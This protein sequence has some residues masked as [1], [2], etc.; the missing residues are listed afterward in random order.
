[1]SD[2]HYSGSSDSSGLK[3][4]VLFGAVIA[5][6]A[7]NVYLY[8]QVDQMRTDMAA[9]RDSIS[10]EVSGLR[11]ASNVTSASARKTVEDLKTQ[12]DAARQQANQAA[13][14]AK[15]E[16]LARAESLAKQL[17]EEQR[18]QAQQVS[19]QISEVKETAQSANA[20]IDTV[21]TD[22][23]AVRTEVTNAKST[24]EKT[25]ADLK[26]VT[27]DLGVQ[28]GYIATNGKE[29]AALKRLGERNYFEFNLAKSKQPVKVGDISVQL[30]RTDTK[31]NRFTIDIYADDKRVEKKDRTLNEPVQFYVS[32]ARQPYEL[33]VN[34]VKKDVIVGYL[35]TPKDQVARN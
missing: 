4:A 19:S 3:T 11:D 7:A 20:R 35:A 8:I 1:M 2:L 28:S 29:L 21:S 33:V 18:R 24:I 32:R 16:A 25:I 26:Q 23:T 17:A 15:A 22:V 14:T 31:R 12:L 6:L 34:E 9:L 27:G 13:S 5:L 30:R 10:T